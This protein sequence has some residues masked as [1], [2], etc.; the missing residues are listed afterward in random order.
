MSDDY[1][2]HDAPETLLEKVQLLVDVYGVP[3]IRQTLTR[4][5]RFYA[6][7]EKKRRRVGHPTIWRVPVT[8]NLWVTIE[9]QRIRRG[10][11]VKPTIEAIFS[12]LH[13][14][15]WV[16]GNLTVKDVE[17][18]RRQ[19]YRGLKLVREWLHNGDRRYDRWSNE[20]AKVCG[21]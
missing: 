20:V 3:R 21:N 1:E 6:E 4:V 7:V 14:N 10:M 19:Y 18:A 17:T 16:L 15:P 12:E 5:A 11:K 9:A 13:G 2:W 8:M